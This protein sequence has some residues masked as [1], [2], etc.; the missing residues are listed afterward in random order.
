MEEKANRQSGVIEAYDPDWED[1]WG[2]RVGKGTV[3]W[4]SESRLLDVNRKSFTGWGSVI[5]TK[6]ASV[7]FLVVRWNGGR[8]TAEE[9]RQEVKGQSTQAIS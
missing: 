8:Y 1:K 4:T 2:E 7:S 6:G 9:V 5:P 3:M